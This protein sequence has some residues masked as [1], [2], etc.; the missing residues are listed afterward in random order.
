MPRPEDDDYEDSLNLCP[1]CFTRIGDD[2]DYCSARCE[3]RHDNELEH[4]RP[5]RFD[6][7]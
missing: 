2:E 7:E 1:V 6:D 3:R 5:L 4:R